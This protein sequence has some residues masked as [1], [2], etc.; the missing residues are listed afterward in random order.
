[1]AK[2]KNLANLPLLLSLL[3]LVLVPLSALLATQSSRL[4][5]RGLAGENRAAIMFLD[6]PQAEVPVGEELVLKVYLNTE[7]R[8]VEGADVALNYDPTYLE[9][10][11]NTIDPGVILETYTGRSVDNRKG[12]A[13]IRALGGTYQGVRGKLAEVRFRAKEAGATQVSL[14]FQTGGAQECAVWASNNQGDILRAT[15]GTTVEIR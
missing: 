6:P 4:D 11:G 5:I 7:G 2:L 3:V 12:T 9:L 14:F 1:M 15:T 13:F 10:I 8:E